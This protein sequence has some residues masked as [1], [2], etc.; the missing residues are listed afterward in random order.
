MEEST[1]VQNLRR[2]QQLLRARG[3]GAHIGF[4][5]EAIDS[6][7]GGKDVG[8]MHLIIDRVKEERDQ[9]LERVSVLEV[10]VEG[11]KSQLD[12]CYDRG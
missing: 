3:A 12:D 5:Q 8:D 4:L 2:T 11:L 10:E 6:L 1:L 9:A 7:N